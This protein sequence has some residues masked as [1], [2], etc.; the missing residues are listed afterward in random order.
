M[1]INTKILLS[2]LGI[3][4][5]LVL[6]WYFSTIVVYILISL[7][8]SFLGQPIASL[9]ERI[10]FG[11]SRLPRNISAFLALM[12]ILAGLLLLI[13]IFIPIVI[14]EARIISSI[15]LDE[16]KQFIREPL[17]QVNDL[18]RQYG[19]VQDQ[20][21]IENMIVA[22]L[23]SVLDFSVA[24]YFL[25]NL[26]GMTTSLYLGIFSI[27]FISFFLIKDE[28]LF[29]NSIL[30][31][32]PAPSKDEVSRIL[33]DS[34]N[35]LS[36]YFMGLL[37]DVLIMST[38]LSFGLWICGVENALLIG[39]LGGLLNIVPYL[40]PLIGGAIGIVLAVTSM[41]S[42]G[43][44]SGIAWTMVEVGLVFAVAKLLDDIIFQP[45]IFSNSVKAHPLEIFIVIL[46]AGTLAG[47]PGMILA[48]PAYTLL[49]IIAREFLSGFSVVQK[50]TGKL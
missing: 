41:M 8:F 12:V 48:I 36:R 7:V 34:R 37:M 9:L 14:Y 33:T 43:I 17:A 40:G 29:H 13:G 4:I 25:A 46:M 22:K 49:R 2:I 38:M 16:L 19:L 31:I 5:S 50:L 1:K 6:A 15:N 20:E 44:Y 26:L 32:V 21:V 30:S 47:I 42:Q 35:L 18:M 28:H 39:F 27:L 23:K 11:K 3:G 45:F 10:R 24:G